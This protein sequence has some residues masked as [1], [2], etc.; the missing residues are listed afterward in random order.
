MD[1]VSFFSILLQKKPNFVFLGLHYNGARA[2][3]NQLSMVE[4]EFLFKRVCDLQLSNT[5]IVPQA[6]PQLDIVPNS[7]YMQQKC[8]QQTIRFF[9]GNSVKPINQESIAKLNLMPITLPQTVQILTDSAENTEVVISQLIEPMGR[10]NEGK[11]F[12]LSQVQRVTFFG[13][14]KRVIDQFLRLQLPR[15][16]RLEFIYL[17]TPSDLVEYLRL[18]PASRPLDTLNVLLKARAGAPPIQIGDLLTLRLTSKAH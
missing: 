4:S 14:S 7:H 15:L 10:R 8:N 5:V 17:Q 6:R 12:D 13:D 9:R 3:S 2:L 1:F 11:L 18:I 16:N